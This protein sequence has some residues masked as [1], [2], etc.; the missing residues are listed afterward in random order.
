MLVKHAQALTLMQLQSFELTGCRCVV[1]L[2][3]T[4]VPEVVLCDDTPGPPDPAVLKT[5]LQAS[6][7]DDLG[8]FLG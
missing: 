7:T 8:T 5:S 3:M 6:T 2:A 1:D 4:G